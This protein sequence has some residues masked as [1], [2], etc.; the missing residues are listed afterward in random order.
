MC[1]SATITPAQERE[2]SLRAQPWSKV[3]RLAKVLPAL[4]PVSEPGIQAIES[5]GNEVDDLGLVGHS[6]AFTPNSI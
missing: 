5:L 4:D 1:T 3:Q 6:A 2:A